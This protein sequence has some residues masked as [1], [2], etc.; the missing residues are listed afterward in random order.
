MEAERGEGGRGED[1]L[2]TTS[3]I[4]LRVMKTVLLA[5]KVIALTIILFIL[6]AVAAGIV[7]LQQDPSQT[8]PA[9]AARGAGM[10]LLVCLI[11]AAILSYLVLRSRWTGWRLVAALFVVFYG[12]TTFM[13]QIESAAFITRLPAGTLPRLFIMGAIIA[14]PFSVAAVAIL[15][16]WRAA[17]AGVEATDRLVMPW[18]EWAWRLAVIA[19]AYV[20]LYFTFGY[21]IAWQSA[22]VRAYYGAGD[23]AGFFAQMGSVVRDTPWL[24]PF[25]A[26][27]ALCWAGIALP[28]IAMMKGG[29][30]ETAV[31]LAVVFG[32][33]MNAQ[34]LLPNPY[35]PE[36][37]R[38]A[39]LVETASSNFL[40]GLLVGWLLR[41]RA[42]S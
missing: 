15:G 34:I 31:A 32:V 35:M 37:V 10:L 20:V 12:V 14:A 33:L 23:P 21:F 18:S 3:R 27:R 24:V 9:A 5:L 26:F 36:A 29:W 13:T 28:V 4:S 16:K 40:F 7:G 11:E 42:T 30:R 6:F 1:L 39:H 38:M 19:A 8:E 17:S 22:E 2:V 25:Q 41:G